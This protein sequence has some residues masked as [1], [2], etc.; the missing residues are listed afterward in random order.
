MRFHKRLV[1]SFVVALIIFFLSLGAA[2][3][4]CQ[5]A[6]NIPNPQYS[7]TVCTL[8]PDINTQSPILKN[9]L[10]ITSNLTQAYILVI[11]GIF[12]LA[13]IILSLISKPLKQ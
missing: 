3:I 10:G 6:P 13:F 12:I 9:Y 2:I 11:G 8:N 1:Y 5:T 7:W 4:P